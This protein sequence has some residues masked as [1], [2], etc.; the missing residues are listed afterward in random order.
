[1]RKFT[2]IVQMTSSISSRIALGRAVHVLELDLFCLPT[3]GS[4]AA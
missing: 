1:M 4:R 2:W 3:F